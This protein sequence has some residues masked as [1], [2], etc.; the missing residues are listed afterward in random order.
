MFA[1]AGKEAVDGAVKRVGELIENSNYELLAEK[2]PVIRIILPI[3]G[4][5]KEGYDSLTPEQKAKLWAKV[6]TLVASA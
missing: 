3:L 1:W 2:I 5:V 6:L 4:D